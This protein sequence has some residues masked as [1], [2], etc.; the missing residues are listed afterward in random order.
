METYFNPYP[1]PAASYIEGYSCLIRTVDT[2]LHLFNELK[3]K[4]RMLE[5]VA[6]E[7]DNLSAHVIF[8]RDD[9]P[10]YMQQ[11]V[12]AAQASDKNKLITF[13][14]M[15][16]KGKKIN[17]AEHPDIEHWVVKELEINAPL[18]EL[19]VKRNGIAVTIPTSQGW[20]V[21]LIEF[22]GHNE[23]LPNLWGQAE[24]SALMAHYIS[25][26]ENA[27]ERF[28]FRFNA[29]FCDGA[30]NDAPDVRDWDKYGFFIKME[31]AK[32]RN[33]IV[34]NDL[35]SDVGRTILGRLCELRC[36]GEGR[37]IFFVRIKS[38]ILIA[39]FYSKASGISQEQAIQ[40]AIKR[41][42]RHHM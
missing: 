1:K 13:L 28:A 5:N 7:T 10:N 36:Y 29:S 23:K 25:S 42:N 22:N 32:Q 27:K 31:K 24:I 11:I 26:L 4:N 33:Y 35:L 20:A 15:L 3:E 39:G 17:I 37:R 2:W 14:Q 19:A 40:K 9:I 30:L 8:I 6:D 18:L 34:D 12:S 41:V 21:D 16:S 38:N